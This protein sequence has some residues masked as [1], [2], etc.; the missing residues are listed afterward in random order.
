MKEA[1][2]GEDARAGSERKLNTKVWGGQKVTRESQD[3][4]VWGMVLG[5]VTVGGVRKTRIEQ[6]FEG[7]WDFA[8]S[9]WLEKALSGN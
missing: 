8:R 9:E 5:D 1:E 6:D 7:S 3:R 4:I 2:L